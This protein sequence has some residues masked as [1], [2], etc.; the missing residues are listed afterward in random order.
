MI[1]FG[2]LPVTLVTPREPSVNVCV[3]I[4]G[5]SHSTIPVKRTTKVLGI[6]E[7]VTYYLDKEIRILPKDPI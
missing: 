2:L 7:Y 6:S 5:M 4:S 3:N 1:S